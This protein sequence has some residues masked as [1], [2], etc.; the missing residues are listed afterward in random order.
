[1]SGPQELIA[2]IQLARDEERGFERLLTPQQR[3]AT[4]TLDEP[5][6]RDLLA[7]ATGAKESLRAALAAARAGRPQ[8]A[9]HSREELFAANSTREFASIEDDAERVTRA[10]VAEV[11]LLD[12][13]ALGAA[14]EWIEGETVA[15]EILQQAVTHAL[16]HILDPLARLGHPDTAIAAQERFL[17]S[18]PADCSQL[19]RTRAQYNL[20]CLCALAGRD[21]EALRHITD[22]LRARPALLEHARTDPDLE[23]LRHRIA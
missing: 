9:S 18:L 11:E 20:G 8:S 15:D 17:A 4:G 19:Q 22:A 16:A 2:L 5:S 3:E 10:L 21:D 14:P 23:R 6:P 12:A 1:M 13:D 7:H